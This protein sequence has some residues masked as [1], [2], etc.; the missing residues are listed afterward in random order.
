MYLKPHLLCRPPLSRR[1]SVALLPILFLSPLLTFTL[2][3]ISP[4]LFFQFSFQITSGFST[5]SIA[6]CPCLKPYWLPWHTERQPWLLIAH[7][8]T[9]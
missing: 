6:C 1:F 9:S 8:E 7:P 4:L 3:R 2:P 5:Q